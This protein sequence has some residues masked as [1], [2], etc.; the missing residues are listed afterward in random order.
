MDRLEISFPQPWITV[1]LQC[2]VVGDA[3]G[4]DPDAV[5]QHIKEERD[6]LRQKNAE[7]QSTVKLEKPGCRVR[8]VIQFL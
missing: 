8:P 4:S 1:K 5:A 7:S 6:L 3:T 2:D